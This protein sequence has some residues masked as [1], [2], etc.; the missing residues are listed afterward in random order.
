M[1][2][3]EADV[4]TADQSGKRERAKAANRQAILDAARRVFMELG[5]ETA[6]VRDIICAPISRPARSTITSSPRKK[7][8]SALADDGARRFKPI[9]AASARERDEL[10]RIISPQVW[11]NIS[12]SSWK[13]AKDGAP[14]VDRGP[15][16][17]A[18]TPETI[19]VYA[20]V[21]GRA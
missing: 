6:T 7:C 19:A 4:L 11:P 21:R 17:R 15:H 9:L 3:D 1:R 14:G 12:A 20:E 18:D 5:Y 10:L 2:D 16:V 8:R 13:S